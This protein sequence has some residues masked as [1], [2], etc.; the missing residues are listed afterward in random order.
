NGQLDRL[1]A[2]VAQPQH[3]A[4]GVTKQ[5]LAGV[6]ELW[7]QA[8]IPRDPD[9]VIGDRR[10]HPNAVGVDPSPARSVG[11]RRQPLQLLDRPDP[12]AR[13]EPQLIGLR[14][15]RMSLE[16]EHTGG[17]LREVNDRHVEQHPQV[18]EIV[19]ARATADRRVAVLALEI[20]GDRD[21]VPRSADRPVVGPDD[22]DRAKGPRARRPVAARPRRIRLRDRP[23]PTG[24]GR[25]RVAP[26]SG[27]ERH[28]TAQVL[29]RGLDGDAGRPRGQARRRRGLGRFGLARDHAQQREQPGAAT[30][31]GHRNGLA[32]SAPVWRWTRRQALETRRQP[33]EPAIVATMSSS[34]PKSSKPADPAPKIDDAAHKNP[35]LEAMIAAN[36]RDRDS[37]LVYRDWLE[38]RGFTQGDRVTLGPLADCDDMLDELDWYHGFIRAAR[39]RYTL[40]RFNGV[41]PNV[42]VEQA[43]EWLLDDPGPGRFVQRLTVGLVLHDDNDYGGVCRVIGARPRPALEEL[44]LGDFGYEECELNWTSISD[45]SP[46]WA[47]VPRLRKLWLRAGSMGLD[48]IDLPELRELETV[49]GGMPPQALAAI[50]SADWPKLERLHLQIG[51]GHQ[52]AATDVAL[53]EPLLAGTRFPALTYLGLC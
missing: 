36:P 21:E 38:S 19:K 42:S 17:H 51:C 3:R 45:A 26:S 10:E 1:T 30:G 18:A 13:A 6:A 14:A 47:S 15:R 53:I 16:L 9:R 41:R 40:D 2:V 22:P 37:Y 24:E 4:L 52:D 34:Q 33:P 49:T 27:R 12:H 23:A 7:Q 5:R 32:S 50:A 43:L 31:A 28:S 25:P 11:D 46:L 20:V 8:G 48:G 29:G 44:S 39:V 35:E